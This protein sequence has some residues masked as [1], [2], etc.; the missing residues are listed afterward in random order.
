M[1][2]ITKK[3]P[4]YDEEDNCIEDALQIDTIE[5]TSSEE[6]VESVEDEDLQQSNQ[7]VAVVIDEHE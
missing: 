2:F 6:N 1:D 3:Y 4:K 7:H 5:R